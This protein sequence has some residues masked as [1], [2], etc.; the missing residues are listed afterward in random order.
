MTTHTAPA[1]GLATRPTSGANFVTATGQS[2]RRTMLQY[3]RTR[4][5]LVMPVILSIAFLIIFR[6]IFGDAIHSGSAV[7]YTTFLIPGF[8]VQTTLWTGMNISAGVAEDS[9]SGVH[10]RFRSL[11]IP[12]STVMAGRSLADTAL[13][14]W[15][16]LVVTLLA[17]AVGFRTDAH[18][19][20]I[21]LA[22]ALMVA[23]IYAFD[24]V[25]ISVGLL[26]GNAQAAQS[27]SSLVVVLLSFVSGALVPIKLMPSWIQ[28][29]A[30]N[31]PVN[32][33]INAVRSLLLG[34]VKN[35]GIGHSTAYW[36][37]LSLA[38][39]A[40]VFVVFSSVAVARFARSQ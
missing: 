6:Y 15:V 34:G 25:F 37:A 39:C 28:P 18:L 3:L 27:M 10:D 14:C 9:T 19:A 30:A 32:V 36:V 11:P 17:F 23:T 21:V 8:L 24:W 40:G 13:N 33:I 38:W 31:Q 2:A 22:F 5:L 7:A 1:T 12:R 16:L 29:F 35:A 26:A 20:A 4:Q